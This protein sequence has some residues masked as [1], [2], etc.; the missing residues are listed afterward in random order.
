MRAYVAVGSNLADRWA[1]LGRAARFLRGAPLVAV[2]RA[3]RVYDSEPVGPPQPRYLNAVLELETGRTP[4]SLHQLLR[5]AEDEALRDRRK[6]ARWGPRTLDL[7]LL[8]FGDRI[9]RTAALTVPHPR[10][11]H[12]RFVL[13]PL[14]ELAPALVVPG[15]GATVAALLAAAPPLAVVPSGL[16]PA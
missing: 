4:E 12:R 6:G 15:T 16:Y 2:L 9:V 13:A 5:E 8:L 10:M 11:A 14:A 3:S 7:D 1:N